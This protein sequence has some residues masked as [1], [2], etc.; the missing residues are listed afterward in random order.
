MSRVFCKIDKITILWDTTQPECI[1]PLAGGVNVTSR[2]QDRSPKLKQFF[3]YTTRDLDFCA[4]SK[5]DVTATA[6]ALEVEP[7]FPRK[8]DACRK[9]PY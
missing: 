7:Q 6:G 3:P 4:T 1:L 9:L 8:R 5:K 2:Y